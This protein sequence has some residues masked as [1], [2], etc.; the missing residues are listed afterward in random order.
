[1]SNKPDFVHV[2]WIQAPRQ[3]VW[4]ALFDAELTR[5]YWGVHKNVSSWEVGA[6]W[7]HVDADDESKVAVAGEVLA[8]DAPQKLSFTW[9]SAHDPDATPT[10]VTFTLAEMFGATKLT[11]THS[12]LAELTGPV[13]EGWPAILSSLKTLLET[14]HPM[15]ATSRRWAG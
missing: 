3:K 14:G 13:V 5:Q 4:D 1:M 15:P 6:K 10:V 7:Q 9:S 8:Y 2:V 11:L 12:G